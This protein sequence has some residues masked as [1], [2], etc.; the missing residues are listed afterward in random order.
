[1]DVKSIDPDCYRV[2]RKKNR[3][4]NGRSPTFLDRIG[5]ADLERPPVR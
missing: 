1:M 3:P 4:M 5:Q 2:W